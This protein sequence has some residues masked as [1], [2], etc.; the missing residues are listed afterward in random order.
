MRLEALKFLYDIQQACALLSS[1]VAGKAFDDY[2]GDA[3]LRS[4]VE[5]QLTIVGPSHHGQTATV[6][7]GRRRH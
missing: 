1:F 7:P 6:R 3:L 2:T 4:G 5:R